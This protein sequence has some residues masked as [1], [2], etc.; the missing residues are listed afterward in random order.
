MVV[1]TGLTIYF[2]TMG[3]SGP[4]DSFEAIH[5][6]FAILKSVFGPESS[7]FLSRLPLSQAFVSPGIYI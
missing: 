7:A 3:P 2:M 5:P 1:E 6:M 4:S